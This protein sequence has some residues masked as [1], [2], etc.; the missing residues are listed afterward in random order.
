[1]N[2]IPRKQRAMVPKH[3][4]GPAG[5]VGDLTFFRLFSDNVHRHARRRTAAA[6]SR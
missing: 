2:A 6:S 4:G 5:E 3:Q 1:M